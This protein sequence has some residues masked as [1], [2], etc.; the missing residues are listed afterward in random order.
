M[1]HT[2]AS[3]WVGDLVNNIG[4]AVDGETVPLF[5]GRAVNRLF[6]VL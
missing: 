3:D 5:H 6:V 1:R 2:V 4:G